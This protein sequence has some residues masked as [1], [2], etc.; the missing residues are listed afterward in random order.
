[1]ELRGKPYYMGGNAYHP[2]TGRRCLPSHFGG[3]LCSEKCDRRSYLEQEASMPGHQGQCR[4][5]PN[6]SRQIEAKWAANK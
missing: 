5:D 1:M 3:Y 4:I 6:T 2:V